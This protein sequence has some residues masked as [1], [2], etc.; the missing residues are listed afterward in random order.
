MK[1]RMMSIPKAHLGVYNPPLVSHADK[2]KA[3]P[4]MTK[5]QAKRARAQETQVE[6]LGDLVQ[7]RGAMKKKRRARAYISCHQ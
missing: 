1:Q 7:V 3:S 4:T 2:S 5:A 6:M